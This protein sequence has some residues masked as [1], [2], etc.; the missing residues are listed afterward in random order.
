M[1]STPITHGTRYAYRAHGCRCAE[2]RAWNADRARRERQ[3]GPA[4]TAPHGRLTTYQR[5]CRCAE[6]TAA[7]TANQAERRARTRTA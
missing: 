6:C 7:N 2:C 5:G 1:T 4:A 3:R